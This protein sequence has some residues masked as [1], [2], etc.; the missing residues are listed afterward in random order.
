MCARSSAKRAGRRTCHEE[1]CVA[2]ARAPSS[3]SWLALATCS[4]RTVAGSSRASPSVS[5][6]S[7]A[8]SE[9]HSNEP[10]QSS[11]LRVAL[12]VD[13][14]S[15]SSTSRSTAS[16]VAFPSPTHSLHTSQWVAHSA[17]D[18]QISMP[19]TTACTAG[20]MA[21]ESTRTAHPASSTGRCVGAAASSSMSAS[22]RSWT[23][24][25]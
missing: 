10:T 18:R 15:R 25:Q 11:T 13:A 5:A 3:R 6:T 7:V 12:L 22:S 21:T 14:C 19:S 8:T 1:F 4:K 16:A 24:V 9:R 2:S 23:L 20:S 17:G